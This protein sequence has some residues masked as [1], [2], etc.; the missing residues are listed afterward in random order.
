M[1]KHLKRHHGITIEKA[2]S[3]NQIEV[4]QQLQQLY[5]QAE[6]TSGADELDSEILRAQLNKTVIIEALVSMI[7]VRNLSFCLVKWPEFHTLC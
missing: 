4:N 3:K 1:K 6:A 7:V 5:C 2:L